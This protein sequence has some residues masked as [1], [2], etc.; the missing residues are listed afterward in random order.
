MPQEGQVSQS[1]FQINPLVPEFDWKPA[2]IRKLLQASRFL[3]PEGDLNG[4]RIA[5]IF[6]VLALVTSTLSV[7]SGAGLIQIEFYMGTSIEASKIE[8]C[9]EPRCKRIE[10]GYIYELNAAAFY[11][12][13][14]P[15]FAIFGARFLWRARIALE[16]LAD[17][18]QLVSRIDQSAPT[19][20]SLVGTNTLRF[21]WVVV[22][23]TLLT[24][25]VFVVIFT[26]FNSKTGHYKHLAFGYLQAPFISSYENLNLKE[27]EDS[28][29]RIDGLSE[30][31]EGEFSQWSI[32]NISMI[33][34]IN[35]GSD[36][37]IYFYAF[38]FFAILIQ[39]LFIPFSIWMVLKGIY[40][41]YFVFRAISPRSNFRVQIVLNSSHEDKRFGISLLDR[42]FNNIAVV[43]A[44]GAIGTIM[45][46][47]SNLAKGSRKLCK[48][49]CE[50]GVNAFAIYGQNLLT[51]LPVTIGIAMALFI[52]MFHLR[53]E[54]MYPRAAD[55]STWPDLPA[56]W[57]FGG[58][59]LLTIGPGL[60]AGAQPGLVM[61]AH[62]SW[63]STIDLI[64]AMVRLLFSS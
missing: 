55:Q 47:I 59:A 37:D 24:V 22:S 34:K 6:F 13:G 39:I 58:A 51:Y 7:V 45:A 29:R 11:L 10:F 46:T 2:P 60:I 19:I 49:R 14:A 43:V 53:A 5:L 57:F 56:L 62:A 31:K 36:G 33:G 28:G 44:I 4:G 18:G 17:R 21:I 40:L 48:L 50:D 52:L 3:T 1:S 9:I 15:L 64:Q 25:V 35:Y 63:V 27:I 23:T 20:Q 41:F 8:D 12:L 32:K 42:A 30:I 61:T 16:D 26:E 54:K 38:I